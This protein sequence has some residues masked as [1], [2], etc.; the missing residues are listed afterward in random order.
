MEG[1]ATEERSDDCWSM[2]ALADADTERVVA[3]DIELHRRLPESLL[4]EFPTMKVRTVGPQ[5]ALQLHVD[6]PEQLDGLLQKLRSVGV[7][8][9]GLHRT[10]DVDQE[11]G[12]SAD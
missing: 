1:D 2:E 12:L 10:S 5:T 3:Y 7:S 6:D 9:T 11:R 8:L 4:S